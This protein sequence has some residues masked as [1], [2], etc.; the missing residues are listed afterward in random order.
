MEIIK[1]GRYHDRDS[2]IVSCGGCDCR[3]RIQLSDILAYHK[4]KKVKCRGEVGMDIYYYKILFKYYCICPDCHDDIYISDDLYKTLI[5][6]SRCKK[7]KSDS[8]RIQEYLDYFYDKIHD[9]NN[10][11][12]N[13]MEAFMDAKQILR[14]D[15][16]EN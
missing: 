11:L 7:Y 12:F 5:K 2:V 6:Y 15:K 14:G 4:P 8:D 16:N 13:H 1:H 10:S 3:I 9:R